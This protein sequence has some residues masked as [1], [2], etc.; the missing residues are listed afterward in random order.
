MRMKR[1]KLIFLLCV[2]IL[3]QSAVLSFAF[4]T[5]DDRMGPENPFHVYTTDPEYFNDL[6]LD[7]EN[8]TLYLATENGVFV[9]DLETG[10]FSHMGKWFGMEQPNIQ[11]IV[12]D[13][14]SKRLIIAERYEPNIY[15]VD[16]GNLTLIEKFIL[17][18]ED[19][20]PYKTGTGK[21][22]YD[23]I[24]EKIFISHSNALIEVDLKEERYQYHDLSNIELI[25]YHYKG[26]GS[27]QDMRFV[28]ETGK[29]YLATTNGF[30]IFNPENDKGE[31]VLDCDV[32][33]Y[34]TND[35]DL[36]ERT[37]NLYISGYRLVRY[38]IHTGDWMHYPYLELDW[39]N[40]TFKP[41]EEFEG[42][43]NDHGNILFRVCYDPLRDE[44]YCQIASRYTL[45]RFD[46][47]EPEL[48]RVYDHEDYEGESFSRITTSR[49]IHDPVTTDLLMGSGNYYSGSGSGRS[50][51]DDVARLMWY[52]IDEDK[53]E[54]VIVTRENPDDP[55]HYDLPT[56]MR[57]SPLHDGLIVG[58]EHSLYVLDEKMNIIR[59]FEDEVEHVRDM[60]FRGPDLYIMAE[61]GSFILNMN[62][63]TLSRIGINDSFHFQTVDI[64]DEKG[65]V[66]LGS[67]YGIHIYY[68]ENG[69]HRFFNPFNNRTNPGEGEFTYFGA[70]ASCGVYK[71]PNRD[72]IYLFTELYSDLLELDMN[73]GKYTY[74]NNYTKG[75]DSGFEWFDFTINQVV[76]SEEMDDLILLTSYDLFRSNFEHDENLTRRTVRISMYL[77]EENDILYVPTEG[78]FG[79]G[80]LAIHINNGSTEIY[81]PEMGLPWQIIRGFHFDESRER[82]YFEGTRCFFWIDLDDLDSLKS[83]DEIDA[84]ELRRYSLNEEKDI[85]DPDETDDDNTIR[86]IILVVGILIIILII[87]NLKIRKKGQ[88]FN[89]GPSLTGRIQ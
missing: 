75:D 47:S 22:A 68:P 27:I 2:A 44:V 81:D 18:D 59:D 60:E 42:N 52:R 20:K 7:A 34:Q 88:F 53:F 19:G 63:N 78:T 8:R 13:P 1:S 74:L 49:I 36:D 70:P 82:F 14:D 38:N 46:G 66:Y 9:K 32:L 62:N 15:I 11:D 72:V 85:E 64:P 35:M 55:R 33:G 29:L 80:L 56:I 71:H 87:V 57:T 21:I 67:S 30:F 65:S 61:N 40:D 3:I 39:D 58:N 24:N 6:E 31:I 4:E 84:I 41:V 76:Y 69:T 48:L 73:T 17:T 51:Y 25:N 54:R 45:L 83:A 23:G 37:G 5:K 79:Q 89:E 77:D 50:Q 43:Y 86:F 12:M 10:E 26:F 28:E 16:T